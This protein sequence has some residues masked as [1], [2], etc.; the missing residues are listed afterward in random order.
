MEVGTTGRRA[1]PAAGSQSGRVI[2]VGY[3]QWAGLRP[4]GYVPWWQQS[5]RPMGFSKFSP[6][7]LKRM[8]PG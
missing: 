5:S 6:M 7:W 2:V 1:P 8:T 4:G 3:S